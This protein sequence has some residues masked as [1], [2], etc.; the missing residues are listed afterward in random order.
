M[1]TFILAQIYLYLLII[2]ISTFALFG[3]KKTYAERGVHLFGEW[4][5]ILLS[6]LGGSAGAF[7]AVYI[8]SYKRDNRKFKYGILFLFVLQY[9]ILVKLGI[10]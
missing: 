2:N 1:V 8:F 4:I 6:L 7:F 5:L 3:V 10:F 9:A